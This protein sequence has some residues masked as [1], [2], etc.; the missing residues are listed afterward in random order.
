ME[1]VLRI[2]ILVFAFVVT[3]ASCQIPPPTPS[4]TMQP[5]PDRSMPPRD[6]PVGTEPPPVP[7][8]A[9]PEIISPPPTP[10]KPAW[11]DVSAKRIAATA[12]NM[13]ASAITVRSYK[14]VAWP[15]ASL[16]CGPSDQSKPRGA[17][18]GY[19]VTVAAEGQIYRVHMDASGRGLL[20]LSAGTK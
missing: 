3:L 11:L 12:L 2:L 10:A 13:P 15:D 9:A 18:P 1:K 4:A 8:D 17:V 5:E 14:Q 7:V 6:D 16:G 20:C 19:L